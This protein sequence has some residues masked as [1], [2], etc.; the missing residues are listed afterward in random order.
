V[1]SKCK[2]VIANEI[3]QYLLEKFG[4]RGGG[5]PRSAQCSLDNKPKDI[6]KEIELFLNKK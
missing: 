4:G 5:S 6:L 3:V 1:L 2:D